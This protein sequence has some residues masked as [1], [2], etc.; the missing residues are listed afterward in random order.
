ME[1]INLKTAE[2]YT[3]EEKKTPT[4]TIIAKI[5][6]TP[7]K[8]GTGALVFFKSEPGLSRI[9]HF[10][11]HLRPQKA[12]IKTITIKR[13]YHIISRKNEIKSQI[14][15]FCLQNLITWN[16]ICRFCLQNLI[17]W[18][19]ICRFCLQNLITQSDIYRFYFLLLYQF[20]P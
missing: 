17:T 10:W 14:F 2:N 5:T 19:D 15:W 20:W 4:T 18:S 12:I 7:C 13:K 6:K 8:V 9:F 11:K 3:T 1:S 16:D